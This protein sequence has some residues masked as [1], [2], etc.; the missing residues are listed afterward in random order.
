V[1][2]LSRLRFALVLLGGLAAASVAAELVPVPPPASRVVDVSGAL[3]PSEREALESRLAGIEARKGAQIAVLL[4][5]TTQPE[6]IEQYALRVAEAWKPGREKED[7]GLVFLVAVGDRAVR[8]ETGYG[9]EGVLPDALANR[10]LDDLVIP[11]FREGNYAAGIDAGLTAVEQVLDGTPPPAKSASRK[12]NGGA[13]QILLIVAGAAVFILPALLGRILGGFAAGAAVGAFT[14]FLMGS[15]ILGVFFGLLALVF[16]MTGLA[17]LLAAAH[18]GGMGGR[19]GGGFGGFG[20]SGG[21]GFGGFGG[22]SF[23]GGGASGRW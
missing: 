6:A 2:L 23:G 12:P 21:G 10:I 15:L 5:P 7:D 8:L 13:L 17:S 4:V 3:S 11:H 16:G 1:S 9:L 20:G 19:R 14:W 18:L 22:G